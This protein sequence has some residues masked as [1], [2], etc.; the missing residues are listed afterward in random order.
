MKTIYIDSDFKCHISNDG[1]MTT[2]E[3]DCFD[4]KCDS[5]VEGYRF[6]PS[7]ESWTRADGTIFRGEMISPW[8]PYAELDAAQ[9]SYERQLLAEYE[10]LINELY[11][12]VAE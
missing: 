2:V 3:T 7:G 9:R 12:E 5:F 4:G 6:V 10:A 8:K 1:T 11:Q